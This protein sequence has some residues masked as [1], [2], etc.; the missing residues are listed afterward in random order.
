[1]ALTYFLACVV[2]FPL[3]FTAASLAAL[4]AIFLFVFIVLSPIVT[5]ASLM[6]LSLCGTLTLSSL[7]IGQSTKSLGARYLGCDDDA[8][9]VIAF[10]ALLVCALSSFLGYTL[11]S[12][13]LSTS[14]FL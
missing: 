4:F 3:V 14:G 1:M 7:L 12:D 11:F 13:F 8:D 10:L 2:A 6:Y 9:W 5:A